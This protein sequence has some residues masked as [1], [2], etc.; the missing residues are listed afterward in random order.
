MNF[1]KDKKQPSDDNLYCLLFDC[2]L[3]PL[4]RVKPCAWGNVSMVCLVSDANWFSNLWIHIEW[5]VTGRRTINSENRLRGFTTYFDKKIGQ[6][7]L[8]RLFL[9]STYQST[10]K[11]E[12]CSRH[13][14]LAAA[15]K[16]SLAQAA[17]RGGLRQALTTP[18]CSSAGSLLRQKLAQPHQGTEARLILKYQCRMVETVP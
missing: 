6:K 17:W 16:G 7:W 14:S 2:V 9:H 13:F 4:Q 15:E 11:S 3:Y 10:W 1:M 5:F 8:F 12:I 18:K